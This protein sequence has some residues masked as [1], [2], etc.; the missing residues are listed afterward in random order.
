MD[1]EVVE[2]LQKANRQ[3]GK[4]NK[5]LRIQVERLRLELKHTRGLL[6][7][8][9]GAGHSIELSAIQAG[10]SPRPEGRDVVNPLLKAGR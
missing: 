10:D 9:G 3:L 1:F 2:R 4:E 5:E 7:R 6:Q 8:Q